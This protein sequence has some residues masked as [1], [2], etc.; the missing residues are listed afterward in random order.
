MIGCCC[1]IVTYIEV[2]KP[3]FYQNGREINCI[4]H[5][6][7][8][9]VSIDNK[10]QKVYSLVEKELLAIFPSCDTLISGLCQVRISVEVRRGGTYSYHCD[11]KD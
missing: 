3:R 9:S 7:C 4:C 8:V 2:L 10:K 1:Q 6:K 5:K 11:L